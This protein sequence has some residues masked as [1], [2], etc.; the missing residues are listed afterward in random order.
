M[1]VIAVGLV[2]YVGYLSLLLIIVWLIVALALSVRFRR[3]VSVARKLWALI[4]INI[5]SQIIISK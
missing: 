5:Y 4:I 2:G 1:A 3:K